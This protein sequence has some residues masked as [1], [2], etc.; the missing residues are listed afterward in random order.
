MTTILDLRDWK[1]KLQL[2]VA[3]DDVRVWQHVNMLENDAQR[4]TIQSM[5]R[6]IKLAIVEAIPGHIPR[7]LFGFRMMPYVDLELITSHESAFELRHTSRDGL[8]DMSNMAAKPWQW[9]MRK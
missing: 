6:C 4:F 3:Y 1:D 7:V 8:D 9:L 2:Y 5:D